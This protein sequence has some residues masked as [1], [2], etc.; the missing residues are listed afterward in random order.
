MHTT[1]KPVMWAAALV[2]SSFVFTSSDPVQARVILK[3]KVS[4]YKVSGKTGKEIFKSMLDNGPKIGRRNEHALATT[5]YEYDV[6]N[7]DVEIRR[8]RC[9]PTNLDVVV[10]VK[11]LY[12]SWRQN[13][14]ASRATRAAWKKFE[15]SVIWHEGQHVKIALDYA[16]DYEKVLKMMKLRV[17]NDCS[18]AS[19]LS[20]FSAVRAALKH[21]RKQ[22]Q[23]DRRDLKRGGRGYQAQLELLKAK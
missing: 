1:F 5:E 22:R 15:K 6:T 16:K 10:N 9:V 18:T 2:A 7:V 4:Y 20:R 11:Y 19:A 21:N 17:S 3:E 23:F 13:K 12:P 14:S 8:G